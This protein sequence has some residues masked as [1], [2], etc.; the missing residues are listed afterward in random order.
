MGYANR[1]LVT[2]LSHALL[3]TDKLFLTAAGSKS[4]Y[5][6]KDFAPDDSKFVEFPV[7]LRLDFECTV[8]TLVLE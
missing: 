5:F 7:S 6:P 4:C 1:E 8:S 2:F 3:Y